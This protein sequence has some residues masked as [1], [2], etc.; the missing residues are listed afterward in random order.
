MTEKKIIYKPVSTRCKNGK[1]HGCWSIYENGTRMLINK[2]AR[3]MYATDDPFWKEPKDVDF[4]VKT[5]SQK[6]KMAR[7]TKEA[8]LK[9]LTNEIDVEVQND[10]EIKPDDDLV[11]FM[12]AW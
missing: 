7:P 2:N 3:C 1:Y 9:Y 4:K 6:N 8:V 11:K 10:F 5:K 12:T